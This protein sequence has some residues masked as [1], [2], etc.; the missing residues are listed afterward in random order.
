MLIDSL[1]NNIRFKLAKVGQAQ[2]HHILGKAQ[3]CNLNLGLPSFIVTPACTMSSSSSQ[4]SKTL[5]NL[6]VS[7]S[8]PYLA[9]D[10]QG[11]QALVAVSVQN[12]KSVKSPNCS[13][14]STV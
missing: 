12:S 9:F 4:A 13:P 14:F 8:T 5:L 2:C 10:W 1:S 11:K 3:P 6:S 7:L